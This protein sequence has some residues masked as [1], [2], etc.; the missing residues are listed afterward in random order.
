MFQKRIAIQV[1]CNLKFGSNIRQRFNETSRNNYLLSLLSQQPL[2][3]ANFSISA[4]VLVFF[5]VF[6]APTIDMSRSSYFIGH[7][8][9]V[10]LLCNGGTGLPPLGSSLTLAGWYSS[11]KEMFDIIPIRDR[12]ADPILFYLFNS[13]LAV[14]YAYY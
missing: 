6:S 11:I 12:Y 13:G 3:N 1:W 9:V 7:I 4:Y 10:L 14:Y 2:T 8:P 5:L